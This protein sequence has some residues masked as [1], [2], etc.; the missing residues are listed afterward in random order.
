MMNAVVQS[1]DSNGGV[2]EWTQNVASAL[3]VICKEA[4]VALVFLEWI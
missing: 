1:R 2:L 3:F 4:E